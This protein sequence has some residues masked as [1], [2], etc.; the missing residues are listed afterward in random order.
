MSAEVFWW[1]GFFIALV[2]GAV[3]AWALFIRGQP[4]GRLRCPRCWYDMAG[5]VADDANAHICPECGRRIV[6]A[7]QLRRTRRFWR[8]AVF[9]LSLV[10]AGAGLWATPMLRAEKWQRHAPSTLL[11]MLADA[12]GV[13]PISE[14]WGELFIRARYGQLSARHRTVLSE[15]LAKRFSAVQPS[16]GTL[17]LIHELRPGRSNALAERISMF[18]TAWEKRDERIMDGDA[19]VRWWSDNSHHAVAIEILGRVGS[20]EDV[21]TLSTSLRVPWMHNRES[22]AIALGRI[23]GDAAID[24]LTESVA[25]GSVRVALAAAVALV[26]IGE[27]ASE[28]AEPAIAWRF[29]RTVAP[30]ERAVLAACLSV[31]RG[32]EA[33]IS[34]PLMRRY[35]ERMGSGDDWWYYFI[36]LLSEDAMPSLP[37][38]MSYLD[39]EDP[40]RVE[41]AL[42]AID[43]LGPRA[44]EVLPVLDE[45]AAKPGANQGLQAA[46]ARLRRPD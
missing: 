42:M 18:I 33:H 17:T 27:P 36:S 2:G 11:V 9:G 20:D 46:I 21:E 41:R 12:D 45:M 14:T 24:A 7:G 30:D 22:A 5:A 29:T 40:A 16:L 23:G 6:K 19:R 26:M 15:R 38:I 1:S 39:R 10:V 44:A 4:K 43:I 37:L 25:D 32:E 34:I 28:R 31:L 13:D 8:L 35:L 3:A